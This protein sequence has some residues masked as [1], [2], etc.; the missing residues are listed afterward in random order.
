MAACGDLYV[1]VDKPHDMMD[2]LDLIIS[3]D[4]KAWAGS[5]MLLS[6]MRTPVPDLADLLHLSWLYDHG[7]RKLL[8]CD[9]IC[10]KEDSLGKAI[11]IVE[12]F[13]GTYA[14][15]IVEKKRFRIFPWR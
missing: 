5:R 7:Y 4:P 11:N 10:L 13:K 12:S 6:L 2:A 1:E 8:L 9:E 3:K 14:D 15:D